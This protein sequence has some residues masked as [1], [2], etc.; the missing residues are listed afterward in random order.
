VVITTGVPVTTVS[1]FNFFYNAPTEIITGPTS[2]TGT[3]PLFVDPAA[4]NYRLGAGS[5]A[6]GAGYSLGIPTD[7]DGAPRGDP[8]SIGA[9]ELPAYALTV[10]TAGTGQGLVTVA[11]NRLFFGQGSVVT[12]TASPTGTST[13]AGWSGSASG[14]TNPLTITMDSAKA[15]TA[16]F[17]LNVPPTADLKL[18]LRGAPSQAAAGGLVTYTLTITN[19]G[20]DLA[21]TIRLTDT[22]SVSSTFQS[23][24][25]PAGWNCQ[26]PAVGATGSVICAT[27]SLTAGVAA[28]FT[29]TVQ[30]SATLPA[31]AQVSNTATA[32]SALPDPTTPNTATVTTGIFAYRYYWP[33]VLN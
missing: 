20:P 19:T 29:L 25:S 6:A 21:T 11:P 33:F 27:G 1:L 13:F 18:S 8:P 28:T 3:N 2:L 30:L 5:P 26:S 12:L 15:I 23:L 31:S 22:L 4:D 24:S 32:T 14:L 17:T 9:Y 7:L 10:T 16:T